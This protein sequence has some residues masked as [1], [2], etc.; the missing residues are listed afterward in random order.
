MNVEPSAID[1]RFWKGLRYRGTPIKRRVLADLPDTAAPL[2]GN[3]VWQSFKQ[4]CATEGNLVPLLISQLEP[5]DADRGMFRRR[6]PRRPKGS[7]LFADLPL[8]QRLQAEDRFRRL[9]AKWAGDLPSWRRAIL[10][11]VARR[12]TLHPPGS[13]WGRRMRRIKGGLHCQRKYRKQGCHPLAEFN[14]AMAKRRNEVAGDH[15]SEPMRTVARISPVLASIPHGLESAI[16]GLR[17]SGEED[18]V[19][20]LQR[21]D[22]IAH[23]DLERVSVDEI[24]AA[25]GLDPRRL[26]WLAVDGMIALSVL[27]VNARLALSLPK[28][29]DAT[30]KRALTVKGWRDRRLVLETTGVVSSAQPR[31]SPIALRNGRV[32]K[33]QARPVSLAD[34][35]SPLR[36]LPGE[37][38]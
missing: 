17:W 11:G 6:G 23:G 4:H 36:A 35:L 9:C 7:D 20:F 10:S 8:I 28:I 16:D 30:I 27:K 5:H 14:Q 33:T 38:G 34:V 37:V 1:D 25:A 19:A 12:L 21:Y 29:A 31:N 2:I 15:S 26:L 22:S 3:R 13:E 32:P 18:A 24:C